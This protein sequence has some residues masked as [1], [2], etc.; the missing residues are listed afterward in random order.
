MSL[1][2]RVGPKLFGNPAFPIWFRPG[3]PV[4]P[5]D[6][7]KVAVCECGK[8]MTEFVQHETQNIV[9]CPCGAGYFISDDTPARKPGTCG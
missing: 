2:I 1:V 9:H 8:P 6:P 7:S 4:T 3:K 5:S